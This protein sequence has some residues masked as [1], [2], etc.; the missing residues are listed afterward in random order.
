M[1]KK[2]TSLTDIYTNRTMARITMSVADTLTFQQVRFAVG[3]TQNFALLL[4]RIKYFPEAAFL[5]ALQAATDTLNVALVTREDINDLNPTN[6]SVID[7]HALFGCG[8]N[9][10]PM[11]NPIESDFNN[12]PGGGL[13]I[14]PNPLFIAIA[15]TGL[16]VTGVMDVVLEYQYVELTDNQAREV[17]QTLIPGTV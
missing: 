14:P 9:V 2:N 10:T 1:A 5:Q 8:A 4:N 6:L 17:L 13:I 3:L 12:L 16:G 7:V 11:H 15:S